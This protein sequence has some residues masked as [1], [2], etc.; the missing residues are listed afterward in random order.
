M[1]KS[2]TTI[3]FTILLSTVSFNSKAESP[4]KKAL[5]SSNSDLINICLRENSSESIDLLFS[6]GTEAYRQN[7]YEVAYMY[8]GSLAISG[9]NK[10]KFILGTMESEGLGTEK[11]LK[12]AF[13]WYKSAAEEGLP[14][15]Q[16]NLARAYA[17]G[18]GTIKDVVY[19]HAW[20]NIASSN[21]IENS[22]QLRDGLEEMMTKEQIANAESLARSCIKNNY[23]NC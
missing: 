3:L 18:F 7:N 13:F 12:N 2:K 1:I 23:K 8:F 20:F 10:S 6:I 14:Q 16:H 4:C 9:H 22:S 15:A 11:N 19:S 5:L 17:L 21:G